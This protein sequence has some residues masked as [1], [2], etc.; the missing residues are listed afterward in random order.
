MLICVNVAEV[1][2]SSFLPLEEKIANYSQMRM[3]GTMLVVMQLVNPCTII[4]NFN[5]QNP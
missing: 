5:F 3:Q 1:W 4:Y 2:L